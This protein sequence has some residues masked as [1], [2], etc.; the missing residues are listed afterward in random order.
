MNNDHHQHSN[1]TM[2]RKINILFWFSVIVVAFLAILIAF[3][4]IPPYSPTNNL[5]TAETEIAFIKRVMQQSGID[6]L[7]S[8]LKKCITH[9]MSG[10]P[11]RHR[12]HRRRRR[13]K[14]DCDDTNTLTSWTVSE[15]Q[16]SLLLTVDL[17]GCANFT[18]IQKAIDAVPDDSPTRT[19]IFIGSGVYRE[20]VVVHANKTNLIFQGRGYANSYIAWNDTANSTGGTIYS[21]SVAILAANYI[22]YN[23]SFQN[24]APPP[25]PGEVGGQAVALR[26]SG[27]QAAFYGCGFY[28]AQDTLLDEQGRH[29]FKECFIQGSIDFI[30][31]NARSLYEDCTI[32]SI[33]K[34]V[35]GQITGA[36]T[37]HGRQSISENTG[38]SFVNCSISGSGKVWLGRAWGAYAFVIFAKTYMSDVISLDGWN[39]WNDPSRDQT[40]FFGE[41]ESVG[42]G[43]RNM[44]RVPYSKQLSYYE[45]VQYINTSYIDGDEWLLHYQN[46]PS[47]PPNHHHQHGGFI[48]AY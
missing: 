14:T 1:L 17:K 42:P 28:G 34:Q 18:S 47:G 43:G 13:R 10:R 22:A 38:F 25:D 35:P 46:N 37:A 26:I 21:P 7:L 8:L 48:Q 33:A 44:S 30:F 5:T 29:Y 12:H 32:V 3:K 9:H 6:E 27:D 41:Y 24:T 15:Y 36:I 16:V 2:R 11:R 4:T 39:D 23:I 19:L 20:K 31:G 45:V 40:V